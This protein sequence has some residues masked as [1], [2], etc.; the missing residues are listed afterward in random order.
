MK[1]VL[2]I[3]GSGL[4]GSNWAIKWKDRY[5]KYP[6]EYWFNIKDIQGYLHNFI[7]KHMLNKG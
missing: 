7:L 3:G 2:I 6:E 4:L 5:D 1:N